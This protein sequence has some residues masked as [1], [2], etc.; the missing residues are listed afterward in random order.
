[1]SETKEIHIKTEIE[2]STD[3]ETSTDDDATDSKEKIFYDP[4]A[5]NG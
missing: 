4:Y 2:E 5:R 3:T 1:M